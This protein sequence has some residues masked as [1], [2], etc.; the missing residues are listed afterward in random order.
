MQ[1]SLALTVLV[2]KII[3][4]H[5]REHLKAPEYTNEAI[6]SSSFIQVVNH[7]FY[8]IYHEIDG[9]CL[10][11]NE[12]ERWLSHKKRFALVCIISINRIIRSSPDQSN[13]RDAADLI[14]ITR[15]LRHSA[16]YNIH[17]AAADVR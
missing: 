15:G 12:E 5:T 8:T 3:P 10:I 9:G 14:C 7:R 16:S 1:K 4:Q 11:G 17:D 2:H 13:P 6:E